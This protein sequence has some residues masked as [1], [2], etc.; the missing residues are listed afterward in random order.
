MPFRSPRE[1]EAAI[2]QRD[3]PLAHLERHG[4]L[5]YPTE[6][7]YGLGGAADREAVDALVQLKGRAPDKPFLLLVDG[8]R[9]IAELG[10][11]L[12]GPAAALAEQYWPGALTLVLPGGDERIPHALRGP[13][14]GVAVRW[15]PHP[16]VARLLLAYRC[17]I[18]STSANL[19]G[20][21]PAL[22]A[23]EIAT[24]WSDAI[25]RGALMVLDGG[26]LESSPPSTVVDCTG[27]RPR[28]IRM[29]AVPVRTL[30][31]GAPDLFGDT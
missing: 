16:G 2:A 13:E 18:T 29:G 4:I 19:P 25:T 30:R 24:Q 14:G 5:A 12:E 6:T 26:P 22:S 15:S 21:P 9:M 31:A 7:V 23:G 8:P 27:E 20:V 10:L 1:I 17:P 11:K 3:G 28:V